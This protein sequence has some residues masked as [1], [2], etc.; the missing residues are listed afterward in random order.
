[1]S[2]RA[3][4]DIKMETKRYGKAKNIIF[5]SVGFADCFVEFERYS[6]GNVKKHPIYPV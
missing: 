5:M 4:E 3:F 1:M 6:F 2:M